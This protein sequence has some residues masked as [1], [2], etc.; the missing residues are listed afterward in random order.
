MDGL[1]PSRFENRIEHGVLRVLRVCVSEVVFS[2]VQKSAYRGDEFAADRIERG[3]SR[4]AALVPRARASGS[5][6][7]TVLI[8]KERGWAY[9]PVR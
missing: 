4:V 2:L 7:C 3:A 1:Q 9:L 8:P 5:E 6:T